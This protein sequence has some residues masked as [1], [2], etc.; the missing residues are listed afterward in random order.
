MTPVM[1][2]V[3][4]LNE[5]SDYDATLLQKKQNEGLVLGRLL[6]AVREIANNETL[7]F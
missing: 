4:R 6:V 1:T 7:G 2:M 3:H 5:T